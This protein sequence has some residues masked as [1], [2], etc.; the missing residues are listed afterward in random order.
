MS[1]FEKNK[2]DVFYI[3]V[4]VILLIIIIFNGSF[5]SNFSEDEI[6]AENVLAGVNS[7]YKENSEFQECSVRA[8]HQCNSQIIQEKISQEGAGVEIC[9]NYINDSEK[10][11]CLERFNTEEALSLEDE[12]ICNTNSCVEQ[13]LSQKALKNKDVAICEQISFSENEEDNFLRIESCKGNVVRGIIQE[14]P[15]P[16]HCELLSDEFEKR[17]CLDEIEFFQDFR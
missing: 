9:S 15:N 5:D 10:N 12:S 8:I 3:I 16:I 2:K 17:V 4:I 1:I 13:V 14:D 7:N 6:R 11:S